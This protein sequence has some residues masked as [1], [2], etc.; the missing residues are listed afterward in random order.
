[1]IALLKE[2]SLAFTIGLID[3]MGRA[4]IIISLNYGFHS[5]EIYLALAIVYWVLTFLV[6]KLAKFLG[7]ILNSRK[8][9][10]QGA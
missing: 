3:I 9:K 10:V 4:K 6:M 8:L 5:L 7:D 2:G 1:V